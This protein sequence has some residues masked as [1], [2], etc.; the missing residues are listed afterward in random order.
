MKICVCVCVKRGDLSDD[1]MILCPVAL[2]SGLWP[3]FSGVD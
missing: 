1:G 3:S 2:F